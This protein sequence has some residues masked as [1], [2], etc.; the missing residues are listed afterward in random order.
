LEKISE[1]KL[2][3]RNIKRKF[4]DRCKERLLLTEPPVYCSICGKHKYEF[5]NPAGHIWF[6]PDKQKNVCDESER[7]MVLDCE[8]ERK[9]KENI[10][11]YKD[12][13]EIYG[14]DFRQWQID[15]R[16]TGKDDIEKNYKKRHFEFLTKLKSE[17]DYVNQLI[18]RGF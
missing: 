3:N 5:Q 6:T 18:L 7:I 9:H 8:C 14:A 4:L 16:T 11:V 15:G 2:N 1:I 13:L 12:N 17:I 10:G